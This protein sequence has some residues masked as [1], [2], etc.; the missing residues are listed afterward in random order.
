LPRNYRNAEAVS[1]TPKKAVEKVEKA[2]IAEKPT[3]V[4]PAAAPQ[5][6]NNNP[7]G[8]KF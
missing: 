4:R 1:L 3:A 2:A 8:I 7:T 5:E 6:R